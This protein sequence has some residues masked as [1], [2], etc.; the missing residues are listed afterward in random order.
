M[1]EITR[2]EMDLLLKEKIL[3]STERG[4]IDKNGSLVSYTKTKHKRYIM[5]EYADIAHN[6]V[7]GSYGE[8]KIKN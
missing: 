2:E 7:R 4:V 6:L 3:T 1:K 5:D 8:E